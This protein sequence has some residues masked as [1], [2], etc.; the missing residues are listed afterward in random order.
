MGSVGNNMLFSNI[1]PAINTS[2]ELQLKSVWENTE[3][4]LLKKNIWLIAAETVASYKELFQM[5]KTTFRGTFRFEDGVQ[6]KLPAS[7]DF[8]LA[9]RSLS[10]GQIKKSI[11]KFANLPAEHINIAFKGCV[12]LEDNITLRNDLHCHGRGGEQF[13]IT[14]S[15]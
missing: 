13:L 5:L 9:D 2:S 4:N 6:H 14:V 15:S 8:I 12:P 10:I 1:L 3:K 11:S 7:V